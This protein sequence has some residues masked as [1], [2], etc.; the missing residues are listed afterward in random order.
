MVGGVAVEG[1]DEAFVFPGEL[2]H[3]LDEVGSDAGRPLVGVDDDVVDFE[4]FSAPDFGGDPCGADTG[5][6]V[7]DEG[8][9]ELVVRVVGKDGGEAPVDGFGGG[10]WVE[11]PEEGGGRGEV[12]AGEGANGDGFHGCGEEF[13]HRAMGI[14]NGGWIPGCTVGAGGSGWDRNRSGRNVPIFVIC[15]EYRGG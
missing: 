6:A 3:A 15:H 10:V 11:R 2:F 13:P 4:V 8:A 1:D 14:K 7:V 12:L 5:E 9:V